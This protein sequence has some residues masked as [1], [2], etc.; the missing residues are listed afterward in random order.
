MSE[1]KPI[2]S[3][4]VWCDTA[5]EAHTVSVVVGCPFPE[6]FISEYNIFVGNTNNHKYCYDISDGRTKWMFPF[7][8]EPPESCRKM[9]Y[10]EFCEEFYP[11]GLIE[12]YQKG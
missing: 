8:S 10:L 2:R 3:L 6:N 9:T 7:T 1:G 12:M 4:A 11:V 5:K